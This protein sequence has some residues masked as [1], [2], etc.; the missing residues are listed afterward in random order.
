MDSPQS[1]QAQTLQR[2]TPEQTLHSSPAGAQL[3]ER[4]PAA[5][6]RVFIGTPDSGCVQTRASIFAEKPV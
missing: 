6:R 2:K 3:E 1:R 4:R 5:L